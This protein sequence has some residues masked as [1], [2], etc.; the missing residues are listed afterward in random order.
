MTNTKR[1][2]L[3]LKWLL[4]KTI[5]K[6]NPEDVTKALRQL[7]VKTGDYLIVHSAWRAD[8]GFSGSSVDLINAMKKAIG[9]E[10]VLAMLTIPF[11]NM[12]AAEYLSKKPVFNIKKTPSRVGLVTEAFRRSAKVVRSLHPTH[13]FAA[14]GKNAISFIEGHQ[15][16]P[17]PFSVNSPFDKFAQAGGKVILYDTGINT[18]TFTHYIEDSIQQVFPFPIYETTPYMTTAINGEGLEVQVQTLAISREINKSRRNET[19]EKIL[20]QSGCL[21]K[22]KLGRIEITCVEAKKAL[23]TIHNLAKHKSPF[24]VY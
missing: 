16:C 18:M 15:N 6:F 11:N 1:A 9:D 8:S 12:T 22:I 13:P 14:L 10:G 17:S 4:L 19:L 5:W 21:R 23:E 24:H 3:W 2:K 7:G 20:V